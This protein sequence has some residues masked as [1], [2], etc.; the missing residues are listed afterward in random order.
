[1]KKTLTALSLCFLLTPA[2]FAASTRQDLQDRIDAAKVVL[3]QIM[4]AQDRTI[5]MNIL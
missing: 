2:V 1:M 4:G 3:E 5:P